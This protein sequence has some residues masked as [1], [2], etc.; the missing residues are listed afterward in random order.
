MQPQSAVI[1]STLYE[2]SDIFEY[3][4]KIISLKYV[5]V[6]VN[7]IMHFC[8]TMSTFILFNPHHMKDSEAPQYYTHILGTT[9]S[10]ILNLL[11][12]F[13]WFKHI[14]RCLCVMFVLLSLLP[15]TPSQL[16]YCLVYVPSVVPFV[17]LSREIDI[18]L[19][20]TF[21]L[22]LCVVIQPMHNYSQ[23]QKCNF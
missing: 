17:K 10:S 16:C 7:L 3:L 23:S 6:T 11:G 22:W 4:K 12:L 8:N 15:D 9:I 13:L 2:K 18:C 19:C 14:F 20:F 5:F 21:C 1:F